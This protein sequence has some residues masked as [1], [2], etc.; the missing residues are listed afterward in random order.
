[1]TR[2]AI[3]PVGC[4]SDGVL[5]GPV[6]GLIVGGGVLDSGGLS[7]LSVGWSDEPVDWDSPT[8]PP[9]WPPP[10]A[11]RSACTVNNTTAASVPRRHLIAATLCSDQAAVR[12]PT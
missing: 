12:I 3:Q 10:H 8:A 11:A 2:P 1:V 7:E 6:G 4:W 5:G 9:F